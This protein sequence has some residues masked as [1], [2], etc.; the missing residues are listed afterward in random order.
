MLLFPRLYSEEELPPE[1]KLFIP[2]TP[3]VRGDKVVAA[4]NNK[5]PLK[6]SVEEKVEV[7]ALDESKMG[8]T[9]T[10]E[11]EISETE[12]GETEIGETEISD[13]HIGEITTV[14]TTP[15]NGEKSLDTNRGDIAV[16]S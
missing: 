2:T 11:I 12:T 10:G 8:E 15:D 9:E 4:D 14:L 5:N 13:V 16:S 1:F 7:L 6:V 3:S